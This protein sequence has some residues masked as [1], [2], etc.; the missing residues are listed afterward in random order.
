MANNRRKYG[1]KISNTLSGILHLNLLN[2]LFS[3]HYV[4]KLRQTPIL[5]LPPEWET[6]SLLEASFSMLLLHGRCLMNR[7]FYLLIIC[8][9]EVST[10]IH[11]S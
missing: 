4:A 1:P 10:R 6:D 9:R 11:P 8:F 3:L 7:L 2:Q 5:P